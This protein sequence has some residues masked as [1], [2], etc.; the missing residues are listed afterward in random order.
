MKA[1][2]KGPWVD[3]YGDGITGDRASMTVW[4]DNDRAKYA[5]V[6]GPLIDGPRNGRKLIAIIPEGDG[7]EADARLIAAAP[8]LLEALKDCLNADAIGYP[9][10]WREAGRQARAA[11][12]KAEGR[13]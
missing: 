10:L 11:I 12:A 2:T 8:E 5:V 4:I 3:G 6:S 9:E 1:Y 13:E 7:H